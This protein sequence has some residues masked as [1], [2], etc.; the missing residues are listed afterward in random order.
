LWALREEE[1]MD[2]SVMP[3]AA[4]QTM[5]NTVKM[6]NA[7]RIMNLTPKISLNFA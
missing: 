5:E 6:S 4:P 1:G 7:R 2:S 3:V